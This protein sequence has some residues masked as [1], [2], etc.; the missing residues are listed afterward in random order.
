M[1]MKALVLLSGG[2]DSSCGLAGHEIGLVSSY[3]TVAKYLGTR[4]VNLR[5]KNLRNEK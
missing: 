2:I 4:L 5:F 3:I 1:Q